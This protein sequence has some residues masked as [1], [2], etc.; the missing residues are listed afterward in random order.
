MILRKVFDICGK[1]S[2]SSGKFRY[3]YHPDGMMIYTRRVKGGKF[4]VRNTDHSAPAVATSKMQRQTKTIQSASKIRAQDKENK[5]PR[6]LV[7]V[8]EVLLSDSEDDKPVRPE[9]RKRVVKELLFGNS[10]AK[11]NALPDSGSQAG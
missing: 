2:Y 6:A 11:R 3:G 4:I 7:P 9:G 10:L 5:E 1:F 8:P